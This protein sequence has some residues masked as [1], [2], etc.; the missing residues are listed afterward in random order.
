MKITNI[1]CATDFSDFSRDAFQA[2]IDIALKWEASI[3]LVHV[4]SPALYPIPE[5]SLVDAQL[6]S[7][8]GSTVDE[9]LHKWAAEARRQGQRKIETARLDGAAWDAICRAA[10]D[11]GADLIV[12]G[13][14]GRTGLKRALVG[15]VAENVVRHA[16]CPVL[17]VRPTAKQE[18]GP[19]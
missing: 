14:R 15:S 8:I 12:V 10:R 4:L 9:M 13:T 6:M 17:V 11:G 2:A 16:S 5:P 3:Q 1:L 7:Q 18:G 19:V